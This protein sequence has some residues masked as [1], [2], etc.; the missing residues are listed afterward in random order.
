ME[1]GNT[2]DRD[3]SLLRSATSL[4]RTIFQGALQFVGSRTEDEC[5]E[6]SWRIPFKQTFS[7][8]MQAASQPASQPG[9]RLTN[10]L[11]GQRGFSSS[12]LPSGSSFS[13]RASSLTF[14]CYFNCR[15][16]TC[17]RSVSLARSFEKSKTPSL[18]FL[19]FCPFRG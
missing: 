9:G 14:P 19:P 13:S 1:R 6:A 11:G 2:V 10:Q 15:H 12:S 18:N 17:H 4:K 3:P 5:H 7:E 16:S 8:F